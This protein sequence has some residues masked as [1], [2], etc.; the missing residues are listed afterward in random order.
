[1]VDENSRS[2][3][4]CTVVQQFCGPVVT[5]DCEQ[6][7][8]EKLAQNS[9]FFP[10]EQTKKRSSILQH[11]EGKHLLSLQVLR[12][13]AITVV[14]CNLDITRLADPRFRFL[15]GRARSRVADK[16]HCCFVSSTHSKSKIHRLILSTPTNKDGAFY[17]PRTKENQC[18][19][20][21]S[22]RARQRH[23]QRRIAFGSVLLPSICSARRNSPRVNIPRSQRCFRGTTWSFRNRKACDGQLYERRSKVSLQ[24][25]C[26]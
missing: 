8:N 2:A 4:C 6:Q 20:Q 10:P 23:R 9:I 17:S 3:V 16:R 14:L 13:L 12:S 22:G 25:V 5:T 18:V 1:M 15:F 24:V 7:K 19:H 21:T 11:R 26:R